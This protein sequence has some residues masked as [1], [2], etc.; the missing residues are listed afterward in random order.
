ELPLER[1]EEIEDKIGGLRNGRIIIHRDFNRLESELEE[2]RTQIA[3]LQKK[4]MGHDDKVV[5]ARVKISTLEMII[6]DIQKYCPRTEVKKME[7]E[8]YNLTVKENDFKTYVRRFQEL[9]V[10]CPTMVPNSEKLMEI[11]IRGLPRSIE[12]NVTALK[13]QTLR[14]PL[15]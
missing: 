6:E 15:P 12:G 9:V 2:A 1:I 4:Q 7:D 14:K 11:F 8:F 3:G 13:T 5:L 10:L